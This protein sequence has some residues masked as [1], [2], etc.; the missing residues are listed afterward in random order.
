MIE[1]AKSEKNFVIGFISQSK[2]IEDPTFV[3]LIPG[4]SIKDKNDNLGQQ[5]ISPEEA[6]LE[7]GA[8]LI[9]VGRGIS[10][11]C[12]KLTTVKLYQTKAYDSYLKIL[13]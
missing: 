7:R 1:I 8:D 12:D 9:I 6:I 10:K 3:H 4:V 5:Y 13:N 2:V 11:A